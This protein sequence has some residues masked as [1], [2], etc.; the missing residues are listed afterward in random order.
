MAGTENRCQLGC[1]GVHGDLLSWRM[2]TRA[3]PRSNS[4]DG[5]FSGSENRVVRIAVSQ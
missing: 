1:M 4:D 5:A 2:D 3:S